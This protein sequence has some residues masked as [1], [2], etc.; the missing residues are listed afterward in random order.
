MNDIKLQRKLSQW[1]E[2]SPKEMNQPTI[3]H[4][5]L[6]A[7]EDILTM[8]RL[9][10]EVGYPRRGTEE[11]RRNIYAF[12]ERVQKLISHEEAVKLP[13]IGEKDNERIT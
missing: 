5:L 6:D 1:V 4:A 7:R 8:A 3:Y 2:C 10:C 12:A 11:E 9:L 13:A